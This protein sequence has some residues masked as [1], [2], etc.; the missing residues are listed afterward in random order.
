M[1]E[2]VKVSITG[3]AVLLGLF[4]LILGICFEHVVIALSY[5]LIIPGIILIL[6]GLFYGIYLCVQE[7]LKEN[8]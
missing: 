5:V 4:L 3:V 7:Q 1:R 8:P 6:S 2:V